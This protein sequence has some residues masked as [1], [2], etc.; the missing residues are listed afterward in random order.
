[1]SKIAENK[2]RYTVLDVVWNI[3]INCMRLLIIN[4]NYDLFVYRKMRRKMI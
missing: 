4:G 1:M 2:K 3:K